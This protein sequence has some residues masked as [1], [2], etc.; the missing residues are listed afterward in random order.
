MESWPRALTNVLN[1]VLAS[2]QPICFWW[3]SE[4]LQ[5]HN[6]AYLQLLAD[7]L[8]RALGRPF[9]EV[10]ADVWQDVK[11][12][13]DEA[14]AGR[15][16]WAENL[17]LTMVRHGAPQETFW[18]FSYSPLFDDA[19]RIAGL[20]NIVTETTEAVRDR[21]AL[22]AEVR[23]TN[24]ALHAQQEAERQQRVL[25]IELAH[26]M[27]NTLAIVQAIVAQSLRRAHDLEQGA[28]L[29]SERIAALGRAQEIITS[30]DWQGADM[31]DVV[32]AAIEPHQ[33]RPDQFVIT[34]ERA[35]VTAQ[36]ALGLCLAIHELST[37]AMKY[38]A[39]SSDKG[40]VELEWSIADDGQ[41][42]F[43]W[44]ETDGPS[45]QAPDG[46]GFGF[47]LTTQVVPAY[48]DGEAEI[49]FHPGGLVYALSG[50]LAAEAQP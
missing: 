28:H 25:Q 50:S 35:N 21:N 10:W 37:N 45:V 43:R 16:T 41:F 14:L 27:K 23:R 8:D 17:P 19:G 42:S 40:R 1:T 48:F 31:R 26:R 13:V 32:R 39:L 5:I 6:D 9:Q 4:L 36:Q 34:G 47:Q 44:T 22:T 3:G 24:A 15:G 20:M 12:F 33:D 2:R 46:N 11:P 29:A 18:T 30:S 7:R 49:A 38:G